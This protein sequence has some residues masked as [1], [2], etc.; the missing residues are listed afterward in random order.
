ML[1]I[2]NYIFNFKFYW[3]FTYPS[4][5]YNHVKIIQYK[6]VLNVWINNYTVSGS[7]SAI[8]WN[9]SD[10]R[11]HS[12]LQKLTFWKSG[13]RHACIDGGYIYGY[14]KPLAGNRHSWECRVRRKKLCKALVLDNAIV[15]RV[16]NHTYAPNA[17]QIEVAKVRAS[18]KRK[19]LTT[20]DTFVVPSEANVK[21]LMLQTY[22]NIVG[23]YQQFLTGTR[24]QLMG[25]GF[26]CMIVAQAMIL[27]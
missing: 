1:T 17:T 10:K 11:T 23:I 25:I 3:D 26:C 12:A 8:I 27:K 13:E 14:K 9:V 4:N 24:S 22:H 16:N 5:W 21:T 18:I 7:I 15:G 19:A 6:E 2:L 20:H